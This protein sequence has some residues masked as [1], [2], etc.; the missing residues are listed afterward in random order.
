MNETIPDQK[1]YRALARKARLFRVDLVRRKWCD[2]WHDHFDW[3][4]FGNRSPFH[5]RKHLVALCQA[6]RRAQRELAA[7]PMPYQVFINISRNDSGSDALYVHT[8][9][10]NETKF[11]IDFGQYKILSKAPPLLA[12]RF[13]LEDYCIYTQSNEENTWYT[14]VPRNLTFDS[15]VTPDGAL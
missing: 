2:L 13:N 11:P 7:Q 10:P 14:V 6:F 15:T 12:G 3:K 9:N 5:R 8:P 1:Y 4:G